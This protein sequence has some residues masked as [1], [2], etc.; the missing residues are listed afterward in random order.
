[1]SSRSIE[2]NSHIFAAFLQAVTAVPLSADQLESVFDTMAAYRATQKPSAFVYSSLLTF[3]AKQAHDRALDVWHAL[4]EVRPIRLLVS[5]C[6]ACLARSEIRHP[7]VASSLKPWLTIK[8]SRL[9]LPLTFRP[10]SPLAPNK[11]LTELW[12]CAMPCK[13]YGT[14][15]VASLVI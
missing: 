4:Q 12:T 1:M 11:H 10:C 13:R 6:V 9:P 7:H 14:S 2:I 3:C 5:P 15:D 8:P